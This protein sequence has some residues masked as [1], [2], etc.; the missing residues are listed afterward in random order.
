MFIIL[1][2]PSYRSDGYV[3]FT[4]SQCCFSCQLAE[5]WQTKLLGWE[6]QYACVGGL[7]VFIESFLPEFQIFFP[8]SFIIIIFRFSM[9]LSFIDFQLLI[10]K[11]QGYIL[12]ESELIRWSLNCSE[13]WGQRSLLFIYLICSLWHLGCL[14]FL[15]SIVY[16]I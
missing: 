8:I 9:L 15:I 3:L 4:S 5:L 1:F 13:C 6:C 7:V 12:R 10:R 14:V 2:S 11:G 16:Q